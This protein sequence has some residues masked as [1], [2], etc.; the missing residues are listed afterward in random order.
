MDHT[1]KGGEELKQAALS[2]AKSGKNKMMMG[3]AAVGVVAGTVATGGIA[4]A[5]IGGVAGGVVGRGVGKKKQQM[6]KKMINGIEF[7]GS[8]RVPEEEKIKKQHEPSPLSQL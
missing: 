6:T 7:E 3:V 4:G 8:G 5:I 1:K 2:K